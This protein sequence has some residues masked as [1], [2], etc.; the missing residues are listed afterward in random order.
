MQWDMCPTQ[1]A[2]TTGANERIAMEQQLNGS[3]N[4]RKHIASTQHPTEHLPRDT[5]RRVKRKRPSTT[6]A[7]RN[8]RTKRRHD[9]SRQL[10]L[11]AD[12]PIEVWQGSAVLCELGHHPHHPESVSDIDSHVDGDLDVSILF[13]YNVANVTA[14]KEF[15]ARGYMY[16]CWIH[17]TSVL[18]L[19]RLCFTAV[20]AL[21]VRSG[22]NWLWLEKRIL[23]NPLAAML[24]AAA[25]GGMVGMVEQLCSGHYRFDCCDYNVAVRRAAAFGCLEV[26][27]YLCSLP[28][29]RGVKPG[30]NVLCDAAY[31]GNMEV[32]QYLCSLPADRGVDPGARNNGLRYAA[33]S[34][35]VHV[36]K[37]LCSLPLDRG[38]DPGAYQSE[39]LRNAAENGHL[40]VVKYLCS[41]PLD[42]GVDP[43]AH[44]SEALRKAAQKGRLQIVQYLCCLPADRGVDPGAHQ[45][46]AL[47]NAAK[48]DHEHDHVEIVQYLCSLPADRG[49]D[50]GARH[51]GALRTAAGWGNVKVVE[52][53]CSLPPDRGV[54]PGAYE[55][56]ALR[57]AA[58]W[59]HMEVVEYLCSLPADRGV[60]P[61][62]HQSEALRNGRSVHVRLVGEAVLR[63]GLVWC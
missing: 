15:V 20:A 38:V 26:V 11:A 35:E 39:A 60:D 54:H 50:P 41:L 13:G 44:Q 49:V 32:V 2:I 40:H 7:Q 33:E 9:A 62:A 63:C 56:E 36:V 47:C 5:P 52:C 43:G 6:T 29:D 16:P 18:T 1:T 14:A 34:G 3:V 22:E 25:G 37:Y 21:N 45:S 30:A 46:E 27:Q 12:I 55:S 58:M 48:N 23:T 53:L 4:H 10:I 24:C 61:G 28:V 31:N 8:T 42:R 59:G 19:S 17:P 51:N 57:T